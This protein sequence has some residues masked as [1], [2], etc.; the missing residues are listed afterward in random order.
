MLTFPYVK[1]KQFRIPAHSI[2]PTRQLS[3]IN[4][5]CSDTEEKN[6]LLLAERQMEVP[7]REFDTPGIGFTN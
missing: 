7:H 4:W 1:R 3:E 5:S 2:S 6:N